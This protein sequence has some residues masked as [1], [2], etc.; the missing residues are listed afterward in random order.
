MKALYAFPQSVSIASRHPSSF[1][2]LCCS[3]SGGAH[4]RW[5]SAGANGGGSVLSGAASD[6]G[7]DSTQVHYVTSYSDVSLRA[8]APNASLWLFKNH[9]TVFSIVDEPPSWLDADDSRE[10]MSDPVEEEGY[11][12]D[13]ESCSGLGDTDVEM[14]EDEDE[15]EDSS[16]DFFDAGEAPWSP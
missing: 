11:M 1:I 3:T 12:S 16:D 5:K 6:V 13:D 7:L 14:P 15:D 9:K 2:L 4:I 8:R 10:S